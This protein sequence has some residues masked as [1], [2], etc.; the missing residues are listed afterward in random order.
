MVTPVRLVVVA[1]SFVAAGLVAGCSGTEQLP[2]V[3]NVSMSLDKDRVPL[4]GPLDITYRFEPISPIEGD[5]RVFVHVETP[6]GTLMWTDDHDPQ[7]ATSAWKAGEPIEY[8]RTVFVPLFPYLGEASVRVGLHRGNDRLPL[9]STLAEGVD[10]EDRAY[11]VAKLQLLPQ[12]ESIFLIYG[13]GWQPAEY[14]PE[15]PAR[16][17]QWT[18]R[19]AGLTFRNPRRAVTLFLEFDTRSD[20]FGDTPQRVTITAGGQAVDTF[21]ADNR[22]PVLRRITLQ[23]NDLGV[24]EM[25]E[26]RIS[27]DRTFRPASVQEGS[28]DTRELGIRVYHVYVEPR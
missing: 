28:T 7:P 20:V 14:S 1:G 9:A 19:S 15:D 18:D 10:V 25:S 3:A 4:G 12:S 23:A 17:W 22:D 27:V 21:T 13:S 26:I 16:S 24:D 5:Y 6:D 8:T 2:P 11:T